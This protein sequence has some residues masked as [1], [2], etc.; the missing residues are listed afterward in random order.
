MEKIGNIIKRSIEW[1][2]AERK[3]CAVCGKMFIDSD[4]KKVT[5]VFDKYEA[6]EVDVCPGCFKKVRERGFLH[7]H[8]RSWYTVIYFIND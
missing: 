4:S 2:K 5:Q 7:V 8:E 6:R 1:Y 3:R